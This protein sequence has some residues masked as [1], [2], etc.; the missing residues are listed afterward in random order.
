VYLFIEINKQHEYIFQ[1]E[2][3][4]CAILVFR[5]IYSS[6]SLLFLTPQTCEQ[7]TNS[8]T[9]I[10]SQFITNFQQLIT[11]NISTFMWLPKVHLIT[12]L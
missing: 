7:R 8:V 5:I 10:P 11:G 9:K 3:V 2:L 4:E 6:L 12:A 1:R